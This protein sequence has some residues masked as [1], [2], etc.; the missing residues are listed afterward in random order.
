L[1]WKVK[2]IENNVF[3]QIIIFV[4]FLYRKLNAKYLFNTIS[5][6]DVN[7][8]NEMTIWDKLESTLYRKWK[9]WENYNTW[10][11]CKHY[12]LLFKDFF[13]RLEE[14]WL[15]ISSYLYA[16][17]TNWF[18]H[19]WM[20][21]IFNWRNYI[22]D[23]TY[24]NKKLMQP[25]DELWEKYFKR[26]QFLSNIDEKDIGNDVKLIAQDYTEHNDNYF[27][28]ALKTSEELLLLLKLVPIDPWS[29]VDVHNILGFK[30][31][32]DI[33]LSVNFKI[34]KTWIIVFNIIFYL[35][36]YVFTKE[37]LCNIRDDEL[38]L[39]LIAN[40]SHKT[41][42]DNNDK[43]V[44]FNCEREYLKRRLSNLSDK[45]DYNRLRKLLT[46]S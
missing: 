12:T 17:K 14:K 42:K 26:M 9:I 43:I 45:I 16:E 28:V 33:I 3:E 13:D 46:E 23:T 8:F 41:D 36:D 37:E 10:C 15:N 1:T 4:N 27:K 21:V 40:I 2:K 30:N 39:W 32:I 34:T 31:I 29:I 44:V 6:N 20:V 5:R 24:Y 7:V 11:C 25:L 19:T 18:N 35:F 22:V 38:L